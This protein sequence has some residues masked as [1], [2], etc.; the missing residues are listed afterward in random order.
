MTSAKY[1]DR[2]LVVPIRLVCVQLSRSFGSTIVVTV[3]VPLLQDTQKIAS[4]LPI[5]KVRA[6]FFAQPKSDISEEDGSIDADTLNNVL[7]QHIGKG[8]ILTGVLDSCRT[9]CMSNRFL[10]LA[11]TRL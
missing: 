3:V 5:S 9:L 11:N 8:V 2:L 6:V 1:G 7:V 10:L 4:F